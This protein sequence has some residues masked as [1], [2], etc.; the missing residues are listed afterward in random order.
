M[1]GTAKG[2]TDVDD[3]RARS[4]TRDVA[5]RR[6]RIRELLTS[7]SSA[8]TAEI[9]KHVGVSEITVRRDLEALSRAGVI[10]RVHG[11]AR[12]AAS[13]PVVEENFSSRQQRHLEEKTRI[14]AAM[15]RQIP[16]QSSIAMNDGTTVMQVGL[17]LRESGKR[18]TVTTNALNVA[19][20]LIDSAN[21]EIHVLGGLMRR[22]SYG[23]YS[24]IDHSLPSMNFDLAV[25]GAESLD[26]HD[27]VHLDHEFDAVIARRMMERASKVA[28][29][30]DGSKW[31]RS[32][33]L[34]LA[35]WDEIDLLVT[36]SCPPDAKIELAKL[37]VDVVVI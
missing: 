30:A 9:A 10:D 6:A 22:S 13:R 26:V 4:T 17:A 16:D 3:E 18:C 34:R 36:T 11:G 27:G 32:G 19:V 23:T 28:V 12:I 8:T 29:V 14:G 1:T 25:L 7:R 33:R 20:S 2:L 21:L 15:A 24:P 37:G 31:S 5:M 35:P